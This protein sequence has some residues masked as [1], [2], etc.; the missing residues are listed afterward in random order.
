MA[1]LYSNEQ[2][3]VVI[4]DNIIDSASVIYKNHCLEV[5]RFRYDCCRKLNQEGEIFG[6]MEPVIL[7]FRI[8]VN[9]PAHS[10]EFYSSL[11]SKSR[12]NLSFLFNT[13]YGMHERLEGYEDGLVVNGYIT[14]VKETFNSAKN[15]KGQN[16]QMMLNI[17]VLVCST[18]YM[19]TERR[20]VGD[21]I[22]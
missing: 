5:Q 10:K 22:K 9:S 17:E 2:K 20:I 11:V 16:S 1:T 3:A 4:V 12:I 8:R 14:S 18:V 19:G 7:N 6:P 21:F 15:D 13:S